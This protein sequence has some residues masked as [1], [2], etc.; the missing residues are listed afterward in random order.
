MAGRREVENRQRDDSIQHYLSFP[1]RNAEEND[2]P[3]V[4]EMT[5]DKAQLWTLHAALAGA[6]YGSGI[7][8]GDGGDCN[9]RSPI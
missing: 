6:V 9:S 5:N 7:S 4:I 3:K 2:F 8:T 1:R